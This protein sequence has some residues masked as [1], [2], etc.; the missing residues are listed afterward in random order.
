[1]HTRLESETA[2]HESTDP[3]II[4]A[5]VVTQPGKSVT[6]DLVPRE[7]AHAKIKVLVK[8]ILRKRDY[9]PDLEEEVTKTVVAQA[10]LLCAEW[11]A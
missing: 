4:T 6:I 9:P 5:E 1:M 7:G 8:R 2:K 11:A 3:N 10:E